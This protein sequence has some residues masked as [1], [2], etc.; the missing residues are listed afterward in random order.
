MSQTK[1]QIERL[2]T[3]LNYFQ[4][5]QRHMRS[6]LDLI[7]EN[8]EEIKLY[9]DTLSGVT[10]KYFDLEERLFAVEKKGGQ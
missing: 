7:D 1:K 8:I 6:H 9:L 10:D 5:Q 2:W 3:R 4:R